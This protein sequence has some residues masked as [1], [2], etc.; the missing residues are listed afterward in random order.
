MIT[1]I[2]LNLRVDRGRSAVIYNPSVASN[3]G[4]RKVPIGEPMA[5]AI[6]SR[7]IYG[8]TP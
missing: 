6:V 2:E 5:E 7:E 4:G 1:N 8:G 3:M